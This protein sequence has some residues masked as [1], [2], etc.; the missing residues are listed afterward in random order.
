[1]KIAIEDIEIGSRFRKDAGDVVKLS[2]SMHKVGLLHPVV[3]TKDKTLIAGLRRL[4][5]ARLL[6]WTEIECT[7]ATAADEAAKQL[8]AERDEN[9]CRMDFTPLE[10]VALGKALEELERPLAIQRRA[11]G[12]KNRGKEPS[13][14]LPEDRNKRE[15][16]NAVASAVGTSGRTYQRMKAVAE[17]AE[18]DPDTFGQIAEEMDRTGNASKAYKKVQAIKKGKRPVPESNGHGKMP[19]GVIRAN[20]AIDCLLRIPQSDPHRKRGFQ[21]VADWIKTNK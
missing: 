3:I 21:I 9:T 1:M 4:E 19:V 5:A 12:H 10:A 8:I 17:A 6:G 2:R 16:R 20:E 18:S 13:G 14:Q 7:V 15:T 11:E